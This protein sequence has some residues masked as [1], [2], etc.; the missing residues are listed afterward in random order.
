MRG[1]TRLEY[2]GG[3]GYAYADTLF[4]GMIH[5]WIAKAAIQRRNRHAPALFFVVIHLSL[6]LFWEI[7]QHFQT[8]KDVSKA[9]SDHSLSEKYSDLN[10]ASAFCPIE[11]RHYSYTVNSWGFGIS[12]KHTWNHSSNR[13]QKARCKFTFEVGSLSYSRKTWR[14]SRGRISATPGVNI[15]N[16]HSLRFTF[17][18]SWGEEM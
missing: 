13:D 15:H 18:R 10:A 1:K 3:V 8:N 7:E 9:K 2:R 4:A 17:T 6:W 14:R 11:T 16:C 12:L 5:R